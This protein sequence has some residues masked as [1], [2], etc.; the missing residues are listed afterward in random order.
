[1][2]SD[3]LF[4]IAV[5][6]LIV[7]SIAAIGARSL[8]DFSR[9]EL[10]ELC[11][12]RKSDLKFSEILRYDDQVAVSIESLNV[13]TTAIFVVA[14]SY[15]SLLRAD[16]AVIAN[17]R[18]FWSSAALAGL[19][20]LTFK[21][22]IPWSVVRIWAT[23]IL[24]H[25][26]RLLRLIS[27]ILTPLVFV[28]RTVDLIIHRLAGRTQR[29]PTEE[30][31]EDE[32]RSIVN[33]GHREGMLEED[34]REM[35]E[36]VIELGD[37]DVAKAMTPRTDMVM[38]SVKLSW[39][40]VIDFVI[41]CGHTRIPVHDKTRDD[42][43]GVLYAKDL[44]PLMAERD[45]RPSLTDI[46][47][48][49]YFVPETKRLDDLLEEFQQTR[50]HMAV[51]LDEYGGVSGLVTIEDVLEEIVGEIVDEY[52]DE[53]EEDF[54]TIDDHTVEVLARAHLDEVNERLNTTLPDDGDFD[55]VGGF[56]FSQL[57]H[58]PTAGEEIL[59][60]GVRIE[61]IEASHRRIERVRIYL[62]EQKRETA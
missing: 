28:A 57:G 29:E 32:I 38:M 22:W 62:P 46:L 36:G 35:I 13:V 30:L 52:D 54:R 20:L 26:W 34:A 48:K 21:I 14:A 5:G 4:W 50:N 15:W 51:V 56:V 58:I 18:E 1:M 25:T 31:F 12:K 33:E 40:E 23:P 17:W 7:T 16:T 61:V 53:R 45:A 39:P 2:H 3:T 42:V 60:Q 49:P 9:H 8:R 11:R 44:L 59:W 24:F 37:L 47:R 19:A 27:Q 55:T 41:A 10:E 43:I 6:N